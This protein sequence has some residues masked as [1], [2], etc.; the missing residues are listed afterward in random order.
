MFQL[1]KDVLFSLMIVRLGD[2]VFSMGI[3]MFLINE[4]VKD[5]VLENNLDFRCEGLVHIHMYKY[6]Y[7]IPN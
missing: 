2:I 5:S 3:S 1:L 7:V 4:I 6:I